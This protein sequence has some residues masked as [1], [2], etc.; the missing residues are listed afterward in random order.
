M[1]E[2]NATSLPL[3]HITDVLSD[4]NTSS[5]FLNNDEFH[6]FFIGLLFLIGG[7]I[8]LIVAIVGFVGNVVVIWFL[9]FI[10]K[11]TPITTYILNL[12]V[13]DFSTLLSLVIVIALLFLGK[14]LFGVFI[15]VFISTSS[16]SVYLLTAI[17]AERCL[18][19]V[20]PIWYRCHRLNHQSVV[21]C[22][23]IWAIICVLCVIRVL[24]Y[25]T[26]IVNLLLCIVS[27]L[28]CIPTVLICTVVLFLKVYCSLYRCKR[29]KFYTVLLIAL[30]CFLVF[31]A[32]LNIVLCLV[33]HDYNFGDTMLPICILLCAVNSSVNPLIYFLCG[34]KKFRH[35]K[36]AFKLVLQRAFSDKDDCRRNLNQPAT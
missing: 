36:E 23:L 22:S 10:I 35:S 18:S 9:I 28:I 20:F 19:I 31:G 5:A 11:R 3:A 14:M 27:V 16:A 25:T 13:A 7:F 24:C 8:L 1:T 4:H 15:Y 17:S 2:L 12:A 6:Y 32:P 21:V 26:Y 29:G 30:L 33:D 34:R